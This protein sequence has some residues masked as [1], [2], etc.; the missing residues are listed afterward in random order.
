[1]CRPQVRLSLSC[2]HDNA[3][4]TVRDEETSCFQQ[5]VF[6]V[7]RAFCFFSLVSAHTRVCV[8]VCVSARILTCDWWQ[9]WGCGGD[10]AVSAQERQRRRDLLAA[11][12]R[13]RVSCTV[14][15]WVSERMSS[16][17]VCL[18]FFLAFCFFF[19]FLFRSF[20]LSWCS[21][22][23][24]QLFHLHLSH[25]TSEKRRKKTTTTTYL[26]GGKR[27][28]NTEGG[29]L[30][31]THTHSHTLT[32]TLSW[33]CC[34]TSLRCCCC[35]LCGRC[36]RS[37]LARRIG[38]ILPIGSC[39][40]WPAPCVLTMRRGKTCARCD[41]RHR[42]SRLEAA[43]ALLACSFVA[44]ATTCL[45]A[46]SDLICGLLVCLLFVVVSVARK[47]RRR[48]RK[49]KK[50]KKKK[51]RES[52]CLRGSFSNLPHNPTQS[53]SCILLCLVFLLIPLSHPI[54]LSLP[55]PPPPP[56]TTTTTTT[57]TFS[58][59][60]SPAFPIRHKHT[61]TH[62]HKHTYKQTH[63]HTHTKG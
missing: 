55:L 27:R 15:V 29:R 24:L 63:T 61:Q 60:L 57:K 17:L 46:W 31:F 14:N 12:Q 32:H 21:I 59:F 4:R 3:K 5:F 26:C 53:S 22:L 18:L 62:T 36:R 47:Q 23:R 58:F 45:C 20:L 16:A 37:G 43:A 6:L 56:T 8:C 38:P 54:L 33:S 39:C 25:P 1:M 11:E 50:K 10:E 49:K 40:Q 41:G 52:I 9:V 28:R 34:V 13:Q 42:A 7:L 30:P 2:A 51:K 48:R 35:L 44:G 19:C